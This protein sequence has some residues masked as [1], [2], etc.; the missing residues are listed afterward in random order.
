MMEGTP[1]ASGVGRI[2]YGMICSRY[3]LAYAVSIVSHFME[4][5]GVEI[6]EWVVERQFEVQKSISR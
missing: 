6:L 4:N 5:L 2:M 3:N 1:Y